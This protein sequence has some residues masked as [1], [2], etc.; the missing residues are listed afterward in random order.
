MIQYG[1]QHVVDLK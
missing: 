1:L